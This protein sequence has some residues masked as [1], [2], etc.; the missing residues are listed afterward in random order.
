[1]ARIQSSMYSCS[2]FV[3]A[4]ITCCA[5]FASFASH[6]SEFGLLS[7]L[8]SFDLIST[9]LLLLLL[10]NVL[11]FEPPL[12]VGSFR[13]YRN[14]IIFSF[15]FRFQLQMIECHEKQLVEWSRRR[16]AC[17]Y[18]ITNGQ[19]TNDLFNISKC[20]GCLLFYYDTSLFG[21]F[22]SLLGSLKWI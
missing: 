14:L 19:R 6:F 21:S 12:F 9:H 2:L 5:V 8:Q 7:S 4:L 11:L 17:D 10:T 20:S 22:K 18:V 15:F 1:M 16:R 3:F 13:L